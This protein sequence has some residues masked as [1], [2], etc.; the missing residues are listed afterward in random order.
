[1]TCRTN[2]G[3][4]ALSFI[5]RRT[6]E[7]IPKFLSKF[8]SSI[9]VNEHEIGD[10][11]CEIKLDFRLLVPNTERGETELLLSFIEVGQKRVLKHPLC[12]TFLFLK[13]RR[14]RKFFLF[15]LLYHAIYV[16]LF[17]M[18]ILGVYDKDCNEPS[19]AKLSQCL[20]ASYV[21]PVGYAV[22]FMNLTLLAKEF[23]QVFL[24]NFNFYVLNIYSRVFSD[25]TWIFKLCTLLGKLGAVGN[26]CRGILMCCKYLYHNIIISTIITFLKTPS[27]M[28]SGDIT[29]VTE[30]PS[31]MT[32][33]DITS[34]PEK[35]SA[36]TS[37]DITSVPVWQHH[38][39]AIVIFLVWLELMMLVGRFPIF[40]LY[41]QMFTKG[42]YEVMCDYYVSLRK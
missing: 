41:V 33:G 28:T 4:S 37:G 40:G 25:G 42:M 10:V 17:T 1:M 35:P 2:G 36:V 16:L 26:Y 21:A 18:Y 5:I 19:E 7:V 29:S 31:V 15:S 6:P 11:D 8:D 3:I 27:A 12:E 38:V 23:F 13:W 39:A 30:K 14:I 22:I 9:T 32:S 20:A 24:F 34:V